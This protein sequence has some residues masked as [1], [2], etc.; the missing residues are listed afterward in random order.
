MMLPT[1]CWLLCMPVALPAP[2]SPDA[3]VQEWNGSSSGW[4]GLDGLSLS[5]HQSQPGSNLTPTPPGLSGKPGENYWPV[6]KQTS[7]LCM[8][9]CCAWLTALK[10]LIQLGMNSDWIESVSLPGRGL[11]CSSPACEKGIP[12]HRPDRTPSDT[13]DSVQNTWLVP[14]STAPATE[15]II[16]TIPENWN[17]QSESWAFPKF[18]REHQKFQG[19]FRGI[20]MVTVWDFFQ[21]ITF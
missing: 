18:H 15:L 16:N 21:A 14:R 5:A 20:R 6:K 4:D 17:I 13:N 12:A 11:L 19:L 7:A 8:C 1:C 10:A 3:A 9:I 2:V